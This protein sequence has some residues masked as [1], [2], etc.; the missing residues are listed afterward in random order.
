MGEEMAVELPKDAEGREIL[1]GETGRRGE[2][3]HGHQ[4][5]RLR[6][7]GRFPCRA[8]RQRPCIRLREGQ[9]AHARGQ[10]LLP[11]LRPGRHFPQE[12]RTERG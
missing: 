6:R 12:V 7:A 10:V 3:G 4:M 1:Y 5:P 11:A 8:Y 9:A 2:G